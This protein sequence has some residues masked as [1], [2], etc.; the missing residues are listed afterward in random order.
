MMLYFSVRFILLFALHFPR[1]VGIVK[2]SLHVRL[3]ITRCGQP[4]GK[5][6]KNVLPILN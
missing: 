3:C 1:V 2:T 5:G 6:P 4:A